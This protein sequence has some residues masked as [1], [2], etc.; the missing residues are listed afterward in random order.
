MYGTVTLSF[1]INAN[2]TCMKIL[3]MEYGGLVIY[4]MKLEQGH[5]HLPVINTEEGRIKAIETF[6]NDLVMMVQGMDGSKVRRYKKEWF[7]WVVVVTNYNI[8]NVVFRLFF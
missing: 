1:F 8:Y 2:C 6:W 7:P 4:H 3:H 5:F